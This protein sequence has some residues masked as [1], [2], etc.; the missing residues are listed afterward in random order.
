MMKEQNHSNNSE[1]I[2]TCYNVKKRIALVMAVLMIVTMISTSFP[3]SVIADRVSE[4]VDGIINMPE[5]KASASGN[6]RGENEYNGLTYD[7]IDGEAVIMYSSVS[8]DVVIP[9]KIDGYPVVEIAESAFDGCDSITSITTYNNVKVIGDRA[10]YNCTALKSVTLLGPITKI[11]DYAFNGCTAL[12]SIELSNTVKEIGLNAFSRT[13]YSNDNTKWT[14]GF[15]YINNCLIKAGE[16]MTG[17]VTVKD[18]TVCVAEAAFKYCSEIKS[19]YLPDSLYELS[20]SMFFGC[21]NLTDVR[22]P[23]FITEIPYSAFYNCGFLTNITIPDTVTS[24]NSY[25]FYGCSSLSNIDM[26]GSVVEIDYKA[27]YNSAHYNNSSNWENNVLY[28][29]KYLIEANSSFRGSYEV[30]PGTLCIA[31]GAFSS[32]SITGVVIPDSVVAINDYAFDDTPLSKLTIGSSVKIIGDRAFRGCKFKT[33]EIPDS[34]TDIGAMAFQNN[35]N[36]GSVSMGRGVT[37]IGA[38]AFASSRYIETVYI[39]DIAAW[40]NVNFE[41]ENS[42]IL[43]YADNIYVNGELTTEIV[44][45]DSV[46]SIGQY[47]FYGSSP[48][49]GITMGR[50]VKYVGVDAFA[51][52]GLENV[53]ISDIGA[54]CGIVF[55]NLEANPMYQGENIYYNGER[56]TDVVIPDTVTRIEKYAF[57]DWPQLESIT[58]PASVTSIDDDAFQGWFSV[59]KVCISDLTAWCNIEF[60]DFDSN[61]TRSGD[62]YLNG[63]LVQ[64][65]TIPDSITAINKYTFYNCDSL[66]DVIISD[67]VTSIGNYAFCSCN[68]LVNVTMSEKLA[69][70]G[71]YAFYYCDLLERADLPD[72]LISIGSYAFY[73]C[74]ALRDISIPDAIENIGA[75]AFN[76]CVLMTSVVIPPS[77]SVIDEY[78]FCGCSSLN[79]VI[80]SYGV[81]TIGDSAFKGCDALVNVVIPESVTEIDVLAFYSCDILTSIT[82]PDSVT[83]IGEGTFNYCPNITVKCY[84]DSYAETYAIDN[85]L[86]YKLIQTEGVCGEDLVW[87]VDDNG[88]LTISGTGAMDDYTAYDYY[89]Y[90]YPWFEVRESITSV[91][92]DEGVT[93]IGDLAFAGCDNVTTVTL[94]DDITSIGEAAFIGCSKLTD[95]VIPNSVRVIESSAFSSC[96]ALTSVVVPN[97]VE[98]LGSR[99]FEYCTSLLDII[100]E[101][102]QETIGMY[103]F[104]DCEA[105]EKMYI[106]DG[107]KSIGYGA[108]DSCVGL[109]E[110]HIPSSVSSIGASAFLNCSNLID[111]YIDDIESWCKIQMVFATSNPLVYAQNLYI[112]GIAVKNIVIPDSV[113]EINDYAFGYVKC[114]DSVTIPD[115]VTLIGPEAFTECENLTIR[116]SIG[117]YAQDFAIEANIPFEALCN[118]TFTNY[119][120]DNNATCTEDGTKTAKCDRC[121]ATDTVADIASSLGHSYTEN[122]EKSPTCIDAGVMRYL[123]I[124]CNNSYTEDISVLGHDFT[125]YVSDNNAT[126]TEDGTKTAK[127]DRCDVTDTLKD[128]GSAV[129]HTWCDW[130]IV[131]EPT[132]DSVGVE[133]RTCSVC[134][135]KEQ[136]EVPVLEKFDNHFGDIKE[137]HW[138]YDAVSFVVTK[139]YMKGMSEVTFSPNS[140]ITR[141]QFVLIL[142]NIA[143]VDTDEYKNTASGFKD[144]KTGL[145]YSGAVTWA[146]QEGYVSGMSA[147]EFGRGQSIQRAALARMLYNYALKNGIDTTGRADLSAFGDAKEFDKSGNAWMV[148]PIKWAV[149]AGIIS[150]MAVNGKNC[151]NP[152]GTAT[153]AQAARMLMVFDEFI[154]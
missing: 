52:S 92:I 121:D 12:T 112:N 33:L 137:S 123:C 25:A 84:A 73:Y 153:R 65:I 42:N 89:G 67:S 31:Y 45:P 85:G 119:V 36:L 81:T 44:I 60:C 29:G 91:V 46:T 66:T 96:E 32:R 135:E 128:E 56:V 27:F 55:D 147:T 134:G 26:G 140:D 141:E 86:N 79:E 142:A 1:F 15:L 151:V 34:V 50:S 104:L 13:A 106:P 74:R 90:S 87:S 20:A 111:L 114:I 68:S 47:A 2:Y 144:V 63:E 59:E 10:F 108:F 70:I 30:K 118:H 8:G 115:S 95:V 138:F 148:E 43:Y 54:W 100:I 145:W 19:V 16:D 75:Y 53:Y 88:I 72:S 71:D 132:Y 14:N 22:L 28:I 113:T 51:G 80:I 64:K 5:A 9:D 38:S 126:C 78:V 82:V 99:I 107:V 120:S 116:G 122:V 35:I 110:L 3:L 131:V 103:M 94:C 40:C 102:G 18:G 152:K 83:Y 136:R 124:R 23:A 154:D 109:K 49:T 117:S 11:G 130:S 39:N 146:V 57:Y 77:V 139:G 58:I 127:C 101:P 76:S 21:T 143:G 17:N 93:S 98:E 37:N 7:I 24:I 149:D 129:G 150:G 69:A 97:S 62:L 125:N 41:D 61:P 133:E 105:I 6:I 4:T 48:I